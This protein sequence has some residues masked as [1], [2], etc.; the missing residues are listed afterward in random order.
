MGTTV[1]ALLGAFCHRGS[2][3]SVRGKYSMYR[4]QGRH[5][6]LPG[7]HIH[8]QQRVGKREQEE[9]CRSLRRRRKQ[10]AWFDG[11]GSFRDGSCQPSVG[12]FLP[13][14]AVLHRATWRPLLPHRHWPEKLFTEVEI[15]EWKTASGF[16]GAVGD[17]NVSDIIRGW[18]APWRESI[19]GRPC[20][21]ADAAD[22]AAATE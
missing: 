17:Q 20:A 2:I 16:Q 5:F 15:A 7:R 4:A 21:P 8:L 9:L 12:V 18:P 10:H 1:L 22:A 14:R 6:T 3:V 19:E 11:Q 13:V